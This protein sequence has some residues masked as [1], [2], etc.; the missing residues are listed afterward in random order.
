MTRLSE[1]SL[2]RQYLI[3]ILN[4]STLHAVIILIVLKNMIVQDKIRP[5]MANN[6]TEVTRSSKT[7]LQ[8]NINPMA[9]NNFCSSYYGMFTLFKVNLIVI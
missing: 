9:F 7:R 6:L 5:G 1:C 8:Y 3:M 2:E 4:H